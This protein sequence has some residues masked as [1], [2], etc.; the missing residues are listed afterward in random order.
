[1]TISGFTPGTQFCPPQ[2]L[3]PTTTP[4]NH[5]PSDRLK[6]APEFTALPALP[7]SSSLSSSAFSSA[8]LPAS[9]YSS[10]FPVYFAGTRTRKTQSVASNEVLFQQFPD[11]FQEVLKNAS[12]K[13]QE[14]HAPKL[15]AEHIVW[16]TIN[17]LD[18]LIDWQTVNPDR[19]QTR[20]TQGDQEKQAAQLAKSLLPSHP[21]LSPQEVLNVVKPL[22]SALAEDFEDQLFSPSEFK[23][24]PTLKKVME[25]SA[26]AQDFGFSA[27]PAPQALL[28]KILWQPIPP[29]A[30]QHVAKL[31]ATR[32]NETPEPSG[33]SDD[34]SESMPMHVDSDASSISGT[35]TPPTKRPRP[36]ARGRQGN[37]PKPKSFEE[38]V[39]A[40]ARNS[41]KMVQQA[42]N[43]EFPKVLL[44]RESEARLLAMLSAVGQRT[45]ILLNAPSGEGKTF[46]VRGLAQRIASDDDIPQALQGAQMVQLNPDLLT[47]GSK[48]NDLQ[49]VFT[50]LNKFLTANPNQHVILFMDELH[51]LGD[52]QRNAMKASGMLE[53]RNLS[54]IGATTPEEWQKSDLH[55]DKAFQG[56][57][58][59]LTLPSFTHA[60]K[61]SLLANYEQKQAKK[62]QIGIS[63]EL[64][65]LALTQA[66][67]LWP[68]N[69]LRNATDLLSL[70]VSL[71]QNTPVDLA[72]LK[73]KLEEKTL[74]LET[75]HAQRTLKGRFKRQAKETEKEVTNLKQQ[76]QEFEQNIK[77]AGT[78]PDTVTV[79]QSHALLQE[80]HL[81][82]ALA[83]L[84]GKRIGVLI[85]D[86]LAKVY[87][88]KQ[89]ISHS[90]IGQP[91]ALETVE[92]GLREI[93][94]RQK[95]G[96]VSKR[97]ITSMLLCGPTGVGK[98]EVAKI[99][100]REFMD[101]NFLRLD[102]SAYKSDHEVSRILGAPPG[103]VGHENGGLIDK[104]R[105]NPNSVV[106]FDEIE[107]AHP[108][109]FNILL[110]IL[111]EGELRDNLGEPVSFNNAI[112][113]L[114]SNLNNDAVTK[115][116]LK[117]RQQSGQTASSSEANPP[118]TS[119]VAM[120]QLETQMRQLL[121]ANPEEGRKGFLPE[122][123]G[124]IDHV[125][126]F[127]PLTL[128]HVSEILDI[129]LREMNEK[130]PC[131]KDNNLK[132]ELSPSAKEHLVELT[133]ASTL[134]AQN[135]HSASHSQQTPLQQ[136][137]RD[138]RNTF[139]RFVTTNVMT[140]LTF[141]PSLAELENA[142]LIVHYDPETEEFKLEAVP[143]N[144]AEIT[145]GTRMKTASLNLM[146]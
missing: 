20:T 101:N 1:M 36:E 55:R 11:Y 43:R 83:I 53:K 14:H 3:R 19:R 17:T 64:L 10:P 121:T 80:K 51:M 24:E 9:S 107:K 115:L 23:I 104:I 31:A 131:L 21:T 73:D 116:I 130:E 32:L 18:H 119:A 76:I 122:H 82:Q 138:V 56:R 45:N 26:L 77:P 29:K 85:Q 86:E 141:N 124:R 5:S 65:E 106:V 102:M 44:R 8:S 49:K 95:T 114:T 136:G 66:E 142:K 90:I 48:F 6:H 128:Q 58:S 40:L 117:H 35:H 135:G 72:A 94:V 16:A 133:G 61:L 2:R 69:T 137:A 71:A 63:P 146:A 87:N 120:R 67:K 97:P 109:I 52:N 81:R 39:P 91:E 28:G 84:T 100:A 89:L 118:K 111:E 99:I 93:I 139:Q 140:E 7:S 59:E 33:Q 145:K 70:S 92:K 113:I 42:K 47:D 79:N 30:F 60:E 50:E 15:T 25:D 125:I 22:A 123:L 78:S 103:Y 134:P 126:P 88:A 12:E 96:G 41:T 27:V 143:L 57:F 129:H 54:F 132:V 74:W 105:T 75:L 13:A 112:V 38:S 4:I 37:A 108:D 98:T 68:E 127:N 46:A 144:Y 110:P 34:L 62:S